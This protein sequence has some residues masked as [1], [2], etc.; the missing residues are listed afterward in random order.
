MFRLFLSIDAK[1][2]NITK[3]LR[4]WQDLKTTIKRNDYDGVARVF[5]GKF[6][7]TNGA[8]SLIK[9]EYETN[10]L[11]GKVE[12]L[13][14]TRNNSWS[15][16]TKFRC[17]LDFSTYS[18]NGYVITINAIDN[19][20]TAQIKANNTTEYEFNVDDLKETRLLAYDGIEIEQYA[21]WIFAGDETEDKEVIFTFSGS[22]LMF[23]LYLTSNEMLYDNII[24]VRDQELFDYSNSSNNPENCFIYANRKS[25]INVYFKFKFKRLGNQSGGDGLVLRKMSSTGVVTLIKKW[26]AETSFTAVDE[27]LP[28]SLDVGDKIHLYWDWGHYSYTGNM[29]IINEEISV[30]S[31]DRN[32]IKPYIDVIKPI[33]L[34]NALIKKVTGNSNIVTSIQTGYDERLDNTLIVAAESVRN[35]PNAKIYTSLSKFRDWMKAV[36]GY[37]INIGDNS[38][39]MNHRSAY[40]GD[41]V[42]K[43]ISKHSNFNYSVNQSLIYSQVRAGFEKQDY[44]SINGKDEFRFTNTYTTGI[45]LTDNVLDLISPYRADAYGIEFLSQKRGEDTTDDSSDNTI[46]FVGAKLNQSANQ[47]EL[48]RMDKS[49]INGVISPETMFNMMFSPIECLRAN[50]GFIGACTSELIFTAAEGNG[51]V[52]IDG[53]SLTSDVLILDEE[54]LFSVG[55]IT[56]DTPEYQYPQNWSGLVEIEQN[57]RI[58]K[59]YIED[60]DTNYGH[61]ESASY[62]LLEKK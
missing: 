5:S 38:V 44:E 29:Y 17:N 42:A 28:I 2:Y 49:R 6:E 39:A 16:N 22:G 55:T 30:T 20:L 35:L 23:P 61:E 51:N 41:Q 45:T 59:G 40:F 4:N 18:D 47:Y 27:T 19:T 52:E 1:L 32:N 50:K 24:S 53:E 25:I 9:R 11:S 26:R 37:V 12:V 21:K 15:W 56:F 33:T 14:Q 7:F 48:I 34:F 10:Y 58:Y 62:K 36:F 54:K 57:G 3:D 13:I 31:I 8:Y 46:F 43:K 60:A